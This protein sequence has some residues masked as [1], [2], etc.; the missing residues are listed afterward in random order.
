[1][2]EIVLKIWKNE[3]GYFFLSLIILYVGVKPDVS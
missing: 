2:H 1:M 3:K